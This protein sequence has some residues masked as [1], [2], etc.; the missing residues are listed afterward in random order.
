MLGF[1]AYSETALSESTTVLD[2]SAFMSGAISA[3]SAGTLTIH[4]TADIGVTGVS[5]TP[6]VNSLA[7]A[8]AQASIVL[9]AA[10]MSTAVSVFDDVDAQATITTSSATATMTA[11]AFDDVD[12][13]A[14]TTLSA[15]TFATAVGSLEDYTLTASIT[16][17]GVTGTMAT[18]TLEPQIDEDLVSVS[19]T[20]AAGTLGFDA[21]A[22]IV[23]PAATATFTAGTLDY[24]AKAFT[25]ALTG[26]QLSVSA[27]EFADE[28]AQAEVTLSGVSATTSANWDTENGIY[29]VQVI[30]LADDFDRDK[31]VSIVPYGNYKVYVTRQD[32]IMAYKWPDLDPNEIQAYSVDWSRFLDTGDTIASVVWLVNGTITGSYEQTDNL[33]I[34]QPTNTTT[35]ATVRITGGTVGIRYKIG[36]RVT[37]TE[38]LVYERSIYLSIREQ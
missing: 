3:T 11:A 6:T 36:C 1:A 30:Y 14:K 26:V 17:D 7:D 8:D 25:P 20:T 37:T 2:A 22:S 34:V 16:V 23:L 9:P 19:A 32:I 27:I 4:L 38:G 13:K 18:G 10:T 35:V 28:D 15:A 5:T 33:M 21:K 12:A 31:T 24:D 29:A